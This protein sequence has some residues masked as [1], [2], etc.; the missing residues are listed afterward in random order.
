VFA[1]AGTTFETIRRTFV[2]IAVR[3][4]ELKGV[5]KIPSGHHA[6]GDDGR[7][8]DAGPMIDA[9]SRRGKPSLQPQSAFR[10]RGGALFYAPRTTCD[11][12]WRTRMRLV[13][14]WRPAEPPGSTVAPTRSSST[15]QM[16]FSAF[17][18]FLSLDGL[19]KLYSRHY[20][21]PPMP[22]WLWSG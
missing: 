15:P 1:Q 5:I 6:C 18:L 13:S 19:Q 16:V 21:M 3:V 20:I 9:A 7:D 10:L 12:G 14:D 17:V 22:P 8:H 11:D 4:A 2:K